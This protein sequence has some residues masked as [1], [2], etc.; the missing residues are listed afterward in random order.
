MLR[1]LASPSV[2][3]LIVDEGQIARVEFENIPPEPVRP[4]LGFR[5]P[6][7]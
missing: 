6:E 4:P 5:L 1:W 7:A 3:A 2:L